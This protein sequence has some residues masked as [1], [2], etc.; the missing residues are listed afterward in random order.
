MGSRPPR[1]S[2]G[3]PEQPRDYLGVDL[4]EEPAKERSEP[5]TQRAEKTKDLD[6]DA[7]D[8]DEP[9][10]RLPWIALLG[11]L[12][13]TVPLAKVVRRRARSGFGSPA[14]RIVGGWQEVLDHAHDLGRRLPAGLG[15]VEQAHRLDL[16]PRQAIE[17][18]DV[19]FARRA[20]EEEVSSEFW[21]AVR[22][23]RRMLS[24]RESPLRRAWAFWSP[25]SL[26]PSRWRRSPTDA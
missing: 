26:V 20:P 14:A 8:T 17:A 15:R 9:G 22:S 25:A 4:R 21:V 24:R 1:R 19:L 10:G 5:P 11:L 7:T 16:D 3:L 23:Q 6:T 2:D 12:S 18:Q 13:W